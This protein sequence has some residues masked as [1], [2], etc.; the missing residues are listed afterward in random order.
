MALAR[1][2]VFACNV[3]E[4]II[5]TED[6]FLVGMVYFVS[7]SVGMKVRGYHYKFRGL[8]PHVGSPTSFSR[9]GIVILEHIGA[10]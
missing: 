6:A 2:M 9:L 4:W 7:A 10:G 5:V 1:E 3:S 8:L